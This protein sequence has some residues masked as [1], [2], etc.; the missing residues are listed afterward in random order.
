V[1]AL[2]LTEDEIERGRGLYVIDHRGDL[3][4]FNAEPYTAVIDGTVLVVKDFDGDPVAM[5][6]A[7]WTARIR[8][9]G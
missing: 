8:A 7:P 3:L 6:S 1:N 9:R 5:F 2:I 4:V